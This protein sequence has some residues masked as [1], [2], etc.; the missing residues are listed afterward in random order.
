MLTAPPRESLYQDAKGDERDF[1]SA[2]DAYEAQADPKYRVGNFSQKIHTIKDVM[3]TIDDANKAYGSKDRTG[4][5]API[6]K[7]F[8]RLGQNQDACNSWLELMPRDAQH[9]FCLIY[10]GVKLILGVS[11]F[12]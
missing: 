9:L 4:L 10:G 3:T 11:R 12:L 2:V 6:R 5:F 1:L 7:A 8:R